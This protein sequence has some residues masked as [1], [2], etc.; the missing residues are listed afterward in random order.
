M[1]VTVYTTYKGVI[2]HIYRRCAEKR[3]KNYNLDSGQK[4]ELDSALR[5]INPTV[6]G[7]SICKHCVDQLADA[8]RRYR[9]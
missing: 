2:G 3:I 6:S 4:M 5:P 8:V 1:E 7:F 9:R